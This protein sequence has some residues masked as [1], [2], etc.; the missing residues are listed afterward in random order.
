MNILSKHT[1]GPLK[2]K[3]IA[4]EF[5]DDNKVIGTFDAELPVN[6]ISFPQMMSYAKLFATAPDMLDALKSA[7]VW[8]TETPEGRTIPQID[9]EPG[10]WLSKAN[11]A[12]A[13][14]E[15]RSAE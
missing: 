10:L 13:K 8:L 6:S 14:A 12:I 11:A 15:G 1:P 5:T 4:I 2:V 7:V 3:P 9:G